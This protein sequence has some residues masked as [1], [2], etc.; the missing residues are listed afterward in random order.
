MGLAPDS[1]EGVA[2]GVLAGG[3][4]GGTAFGTLEPRPLVEVEL[5]AVGVELV[6]GRA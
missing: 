3:E 5:G 2:M 1:T 4:V 6:D